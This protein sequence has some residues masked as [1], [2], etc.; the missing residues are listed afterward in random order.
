MN[1]TNSVLLGGP[2]VE[3]I[4]HHNGNV[5]IL[6]APQASTN[7]NV[8]LLPD[9]SDGTSIDM[10]NPFVLMKTPPPTATQLRAQV[11]DVA[12]NDYFGIVEY[13]PDNTHYV[14]GMV[15]ATGTPGP[16]AQFY[17]GA[18]EL[19][20]DG[21]NMMLV[22]TDVYSF[23]SQGNGPTSGLPALQF[24]LAVDTTASN[25]RE[26]GTGL[27]PLSTLAVGGASVQVVAADLSNLAQPTLL[28]G[29]VQEANLFTFAPQALKSAAVLL[30]SDKQPLSQN[31]AFVAFPGSAAVIGPG[32]RVAPPST[33]L[34][35][36]LYDIASAKAV[37]TIGGSGQNLLVGNARIYSTALDHWPNALLGAVSFDVAWIEHDPNGFD[38]LFYQKLQCD[39]Q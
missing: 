9:M 25:Q 7:F 22:G 18:N 1:G 15:H 20:L 13:M 31:A 21:Q 19:S 11:I 2:R 5:H 24:K 32:S 27:F 29:N 12:P 26:L 33:G 35:F 23:A 10:T 30:D 36:V 4:F 34:N 14:A 16:F 3:Q 8:Y 37:V 6:T 17:S 39:P 28:M 38:A